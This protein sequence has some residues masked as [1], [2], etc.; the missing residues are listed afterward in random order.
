MSKKLLSIGVLICLWSCGFAQQ[1]VQGIVFDAQTKQRVST[2]YLYNTKADTGVYNNLKGEFSIAAKP[3]D[4]LLIAAHGYFA[5]TVQVTDQHTIALY[6]ERSSIWLNDVYVFGQKSPA[7][8]LQEKKDAFP[9]IFEERQALLTAGHSGAGL[10]IDALYSLISREGKNARNLR[11]IIERDYREAII[12]YRFSKSMVAAATGLRGKE[13][14]EF[15]FNFRP[16]YYFVLNA[17]DYQLAQYIKQS[18]QDYRR[19]PG[20]QREEPLVPIPTDSSQ[21]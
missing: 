4:V 13:L 8:M 10:S 12:D 14:E 16:S 1:K 3:G 7:E 20:F 9:S 17:N 15:M 18:F 11:R 6:L 21:F 5:D 19:H 2:V